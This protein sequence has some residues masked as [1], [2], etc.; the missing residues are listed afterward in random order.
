MISAAVESMTDRNSKRHVCA[1]HADTKSC[2]LP[3]VVLLSDMMIA[4]QL[5]SVDAEELQQVLKFSLAVVC[6]RH[7]AGR[8]PL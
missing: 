3:F 6:G 4:V 8:C 5:R 2:G 1:Y 7:D